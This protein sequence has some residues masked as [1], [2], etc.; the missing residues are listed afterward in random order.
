[1]Y[2]YNQGAQALS[3]QIQYFFNKHLFF[4]SNFFFKNILS[5]KNLRRE[6]GLLIII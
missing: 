3:I 4:L 6:R 5:R 1:M 2:L